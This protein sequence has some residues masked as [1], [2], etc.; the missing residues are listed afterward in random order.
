MNICS[1]SS[2][3]SNDKNISSLVMIFFADAVAMTVEM[4]AARI[5]SPYFG[6]SNA[7]WTAVIGVILLASSIGNYYGGKK[8]DKHEVE[9]MIASLLFKTSIWLLV[10]SLFG[11]LLSMV[12]AKNLHGMVEIGALISSLALFFIPAIALGMITPMLMRKALKGMENGEMTGKFYATMTAGGLTGTFVGGFILIPSMGCQQMIGALAILL[13]WMAF[14]IRKRK[15]TFF[16]AVIVSCLA[17]VII[18]ELDSLDKE[19]SDKILNGK[20]Y[21][22]M[23]FDTK[24]G[25]VTIYNGVND[26]GDS[27]RFMNVSGGHYSAA[28]LNPNKKYELAF[29]YTRAYDYAVKCFEQ[30]P[31]CMMIGGAGYSYPQ[32]LISHYSGTKMDVVEIDPEIT[33]VAREYFHL[34]EFEREYNAND[35]K[36]LAIYHED[37]RVFLNNTDKSYDIIMNDAFAG[38]VPVRQLATVEA[39]KTIKDRLKNGGIYATNI[40]LLPGKVAFPRCEYHTLTKVFKHVYVI[41]VSGRDV[42]KQN[43]MM[44]ASDRQ[45]KLDADTVFIHHLPEDVVF[46]DNFS[47]VER[48]ASYAKF[49]DISLSG[50]EQLPNL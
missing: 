15:S 17:A 2:P 4:V 8:A 24:D 38:E 26:E 12:L 27:V 9:P 5:L 36:R 32:Y 10:L 39:A 40:L 48:V 21:L 3:N 35:N 13:G 7:V 42:K 29:P 44:L 41:P 28:Y 18:V 23:S 20:L 22:K 19:S 37:G 31:Y 50:A 47:P 45:L 14:F 46:T 43:L 1:K 6:S 49:K 34:A 30:P 25:H 11:D 33:R 16:K